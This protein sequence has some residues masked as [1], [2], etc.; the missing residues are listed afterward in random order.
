MASSLT[1]VLSLENVEGYSNGPNWDI[2]D[3][4]A[5]RDLLTLDNSLD[6]EY[7]SHLLYGKSLPINF[8]TWNHTNQSTGNDKNC[9]AH[10]TRAVTRLKHIFITLHKPGRVA[11]KEC[12]DCY[13]PAS[14]N[15]QITLA[16]EHSYQVQTGSK[17]IPEY[18]VSNVT[19]SYMQLKKTIGRAFN[20]HSSWYR[21]R[22]YII[23]LDLEQ[24]SG[25]GFS[26]ITT[27]AGDLLTLN[28]KDCDG[29]GVA[30]SVPTR[31]CC[32]LNY[33]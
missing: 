9:S 20:M 27:K 19:E 29:K 14:A 24:F 31:V 32:T 33:D 26:G 30:D 17:L 28:F 2:R 3:I 1:D 8:N 16:D 15:G 4:R 22:K 6:N 25:A 21:S 13:H 11:H 23:G 12:N 10:I 18:P 5:F 7:A